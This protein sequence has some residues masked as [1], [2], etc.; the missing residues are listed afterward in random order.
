LLGRLPSI[1]EFNYWVG[2]M[3]SGVSA[4]EV[5]SQFLTSTEYLDLT[6]NSL[7]EQLLNR[8]AD[9]AGMAY[10]LAQ[11]QSGATAQTLEAALAASD[12][13]YNA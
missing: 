3:N 9:A 6:I 1:D 4:E 12:E 10:W 13:F 2:Q 5:V 11:L 7:Y 8:P